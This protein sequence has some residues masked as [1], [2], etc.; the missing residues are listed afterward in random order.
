MTRRS[1]LCF[2]TKLKSNSLT[3]SRLAS[4]H[5]CSSLS[6]TKRAERTTRVTEHTFT[7]ALA[8]PNVEELHHCRRLDVHIISSSPR[9]FLTRSTF[10]PPPHIRLAHRTLPIEALM[11]SFYI[12][13]TAY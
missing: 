11:C 5:P 10:L 4:P 7:Q 3:G 6:A 12:Y 8:S 9:R 2:F 1:S 13:G